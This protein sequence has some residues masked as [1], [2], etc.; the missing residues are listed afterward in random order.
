MWALPCIIYY[1]Y[2]WIHIWKVHK[3]NRLNNGCL[4]VCDT[5]GNRTGATHRGR[6]TWICSSR[7]TCVVTLIFKDIHFICCCHHRDIVLSVAGSL[8]CNFDCIVVQPQIDIYFFHKVQRT[9]RT[10]WILCLQKVYTCTVD[11]GWTHFSFLE[12]ELN[13]VV[14]CSLEKE[15]WLL[16]EQCERD[17]IHNWSLSFTHIPSLHTIGCDSCAIISVG[18]TV[19]SEMSN[20]LCNLYH[21]HFCDLRYLQYH[22]LDCKESSPHAA[23]RHNNSTI[24]DWQ[25]IWTPRRW[26]WSWD[27]CHISFICCLFDGQWS[28]SSHIHGVY[29]QMEIKLWSQKVTS[30]HWWYFCIF[31]LSRGKIKFL[32][33]FISLD[34]EKRWICRQTHKKNLMAWKVTF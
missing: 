17:P 30:M 29:V 27:V 28:L 9:L 15:K 1:P 33:I 32:S 10:P 4:S 18:G 5:V 20:V 25:T 3:C 23:K 7:E 8:C 6:S 12:S 26:L 13:F 21:C 31:H 24:T 34:Q 22:L 2:E 16:R 14:S 11:S 19:V